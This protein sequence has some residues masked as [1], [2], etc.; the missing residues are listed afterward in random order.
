M[1]NDVYT[2]KLIKSFTMSTMYS[3]LAVEEEEANRA[4]SIRCG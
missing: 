1:D 2:F 3:V 4:A